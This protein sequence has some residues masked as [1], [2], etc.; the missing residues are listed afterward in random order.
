MTVDGPVH[1]PVIT[2]S[3]GSSKEPLDIL[4]HGMVVVPGLAMSN[5]PR[6]H[7]PNGYKHYDTS[8]RLEQRYGHREASAYERMVYSPSK[9][10]VD[11]W[12]S[13]AVKLSFLIGNG[14]DPDP[15]D[16][17]RLVTQSV[18]DLRVRE[19]S[20][21]PLWVSDPRGGDRG[22]SISDGEEEYVTLDYNYNPRGSAPTTPRGS[23]PTTPRASGTPSP[24]ASGTPSPRGYH[25]IQPN[26]HRHSYNPGYINRELYPNPRANHMLTQTRPPMVS[27]HQSVENDTSVETLQRKKTNALRKVAETFGLA[28]AP[29]GVETDCGEEGNVR[30]KR[31]RS[32]PDLQADGAENVSCYSDDEDGDDF[33][34]RNS[35]YSSAASNCSPSPSTASPGM[36]KAKSPSPGR[37]KIL[38]KRWRSKTKPVPNVTASSLWSPEVGE[39]FALHDFLYSVHV[40]M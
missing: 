9:M 25:T 8:S 10:H 34:F 7:I 27:R 17:C 22:A 1:C 11:P 24:R 16:N 5:R 36:L 14:P 38:P 32:L 3:F 30:R 4:P 18:T 12:N 19:D 6:L 33:G 23:G 40:Q 15:R 37:R 20:G 26:R 29:K 28:R 35:P 39:M 13:S 2:A 31:S 21:V